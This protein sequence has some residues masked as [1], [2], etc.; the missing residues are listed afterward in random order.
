[1][2][3]FAEAEARQ[4]VIL[5]PADKQPKAK[6]NVILTKEA[7]Q[8]LADKLRNMSPDQKIQWYKG[9][10]AKREAENRRSKVQLTDT[11]AVT[12]TVG[13]FPL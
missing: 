9:E 11:V 6:R 2:Q 13:G 12:S 8:G 1:M 7:A 5:K 4:L 3:C 10:K